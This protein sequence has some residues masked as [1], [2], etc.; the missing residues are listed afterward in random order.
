MNSRPI[1]VGYNETVNKAASRM[2]RE[3]CREILVMDGNEFVG[4]LASRDLVKKKIDVPDRTGIKSFITRIIPISDKTPIIEM[5]NS[6]LINDYKAL[7][8]RDSKGK[9]RLITKLDLLKM[10]K[11]NIVFRDKKARDVMNFPYSMSGSDSLTVARSLIRSLNLS[12]LPILG[13]ENRLE[14]IVD[15]LDLLR[16]IV[17]RR[18]SSRDELSKKETR[19]DDISIKSLMNKNPVRTG[20]DQDLKKVINGMIRQKSPTMMITEGNKV[21]GIITPRDMLKLIGRDVEGVYVTVS[22]LQD[23]DNFIKTVVD[24]EISN[25]VRKLGKIV[26]IDNLILHVD[27]HHQ[28]G[29]RSEY[30]VKGRLITRKGMFFA[31]DSAWDVTKAVRGVLQK[32]EKGIIKRKEKR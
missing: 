16:G 7:P 6:M 30:S 12:R 26:K 9:V 5:L 24:E 10:V 31:N 23:D 2:I 14:G 19:I 29:K 1:M 13:K 20:P 32:L 25:E 3:K 17:T 4:V 21:M 11:D 18:R 15:T 8:V 28:T 22:G 27:K